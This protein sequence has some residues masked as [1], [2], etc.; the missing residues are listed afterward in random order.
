MDFSSRTPPRAGAWLRS[1]GETFSPASSRGAADRD[2][3]R[4][5]GDRSWDDKRRN[6]G[7]YY[8]RD[9]GNSRKD[10][11]ELIEFGR[12]AKGV[13]DSYLP[14][15]PQMHGPPY[16]EASKYDE[17]AIVKEIKEQARR[18]AMDDMR[19]GFYP[20]TSDNWSRREG[21]SRRVDGGERGSYGT[22]QH[23]QKQERL[24]DVDRVKRDQ[25]DNRAWGRSRNVSRD[26]EQRDEGRIGRLV[27]DIVWLIL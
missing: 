12:D 22:G 5:H 20:A 15:V 26:R 3:V 27:F 19:R 7:D 11:D 2:L 24:P 14:P 8:A 17:D 18:N 16:S 23:E 9:A 10:R 25:A 13:P 1:G 21:D 6:T 4:R